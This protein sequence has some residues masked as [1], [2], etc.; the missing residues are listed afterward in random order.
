MFLS[1][2]YFGRVNR[3]YDFRR[4]LP[5]LSHHCRMVARSFVETT[6]CKIDSDPWSF[7][8]ATFGHETTTALPRKQHAIDIIG[9]HRRARVVSHEQNNI[10]NNRDGSQTP[11]GLP[12][13]TL[14]NFETLVWQQR[15]PST[16]TSVSRIPLSPRSLLQEPRFSLWW[17]FRRTPLPLFVS[18]NYY[19]SLDLQ[20]HAPISQ[21]SRQTNLFPL[22]WPNKSFLIWISLA[23][24]LLP[25]SSSTLVFVF[26]ESSPLKKKIKSFY[27]A[28]AKNLFRCLKRSKNNDPHSL[29][30]LTTMLPK[31]ISPM[32]FWIA[33][34]SIYY[35]MA[36]VVDAD[37]ITPSVTVSISLN[38]EN[39]LV[40]VQQ[41]TFTAPLEISNP[42]PSNLGLDFFGNGA[43][44]GALGTGSIF[45]YLIP[46]ER[47]NVNL[48][49]LMSGG[50]LIAYASSPT[51]DIKIFY[52]GSFATNPQ[53][54]VEQGIMNGDSV[55]GSAVSQDEFASL[56]AAKFV[57]G[58]TC[59]FEYDADNN[60]DL[61][62]AIHWIIERSET[63]TPSE[64]SS[65]SMMPSESSAP[66]KSSS[67][68]M[69]P[70]KSSAPSMMPSE[71]SAPSES[72]SPSMMPS[73]SS[74]P[75]MM[76]SESSSPSSL[77]SMMPSESSSPSSLPSMMPSESSSPSMMPSDTPSDT[78][79]DIPSDTPSE[80]PSFCLKS[81]TKSPGK[82]T[83]SPGKGTKSPGKGKGTKSP[84][85]SCFTSAFPTPEVKTKSP[86]K[87]TKS[88]GKG[89]TTRRLI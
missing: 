75:S 51:P 84:V 76:P 79:S 59:T 3:S 64:S 15:R 39:K 67:P 62:T 26:R 48:D 43:S 25:L 32:S 16:T 77:P 46:K 1:T 37:P 11:D 86:G 89:Q 38:E 36:A 65:P 4:H 13:S 21:E 20:H 8:Q 28:R 73:E 70:S 27:N 45:T 71:S 52:A 85:Q 9:R 47:I 33:L 68:S 88:P 5:I 34:S 18:R 41:G 44:I 60:G 24:I 63:M 14:T 35:W 17:L 40:F 69:M 74:S 50:G 42:I 80:Q 54:T 55:D 23:R 12:E 72:S 19:S 83:K 81:K 66:S 53:L 22:F 56:E 2:Y 10:C 29:F 6:T 82:G 57:E 78:P 87:G 31:T 61:D 7:S 49:C 30:L 58:A